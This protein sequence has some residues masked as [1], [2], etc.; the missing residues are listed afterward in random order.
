MKALR[1]RQVSKRIAL[2]TH[3]KFIPLRHF[4]IPFKTK[5]TDLPVNWITLAKARPRDDPCVILR[6]AEERIIMTHSALDHSYLL[7]INLTVYEFYEAVIADLIDRGALT[8]GIHR[9]EGRL[10]R[11]IDTPS[12]LITAE[13]DFK[14]VDL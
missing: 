10:W 6:V 9:T 3:N 5:I 11:E 7:D 12:D 13:V 2:R 8:L 1:G 4:L 14:E